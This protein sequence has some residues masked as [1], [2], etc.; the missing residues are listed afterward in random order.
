MASIYPSKFA[1]IIP[2]H[3]L[4]LSTKPAFGLIGG[5]AAYIHSRFSVFVAPN[6][7]PTI[8]HENTRA[9][10]FPQSFKSQIF[11]MP[12]KKYFSHLPINPNG[13]GIGSSSGCGCRKCQ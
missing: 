7:E 9:E 12:A 3:I 4:A 13:S 6:K 8:I 10:Q 5:T 2:A 11:S 1:S